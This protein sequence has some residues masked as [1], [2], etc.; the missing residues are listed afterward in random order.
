LKARFTASVEQPRDQGWFTNR[1]LGEWTYL[2]GLAVGW[3]RGVGWVLEALVVQTIHRSVNPHVAVSILSHEC[4]NRNPP[5]PDAPGC[6]DKCT[7]NLKRQALCPWPFS[8]ALPPSA[9]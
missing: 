9:R 8:H 5:M 3:C 6:A 2:L 4:S 1:F 7:D